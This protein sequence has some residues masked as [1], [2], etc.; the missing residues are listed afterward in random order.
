MTDPRAATL[1]DPPRRPLRVA[2]AD[3][4]LLRHLLLGLA[5][6]AALYVLSVIFGQF[7]DLRLATGAYYFCALAG[8]TFL[9][10]LNGQVSLGHGAMMGVGAYTAALLIGDE[11]WPL[12]PALAAA[13]AA[14]AVVGLIAGA[15]AARLR[16][17]YVAGATLALA[18]GLPGV[19]EKFSS[20][21]GGDN[22]LTVN[23]SIPPS[24]SIPLER[25]QA[26][27]AGLAA[28]IVLVLLANLRRSHFG[29]A[30][31]AVADDEVAAELA[32]LHLART[33]VLAFVTSSACA[34]LAGGLLVMV[35]SLV[36][37]LAFPL[38]LSFSLLTGVVLGGLGSLAGAVWGAI[39]LVMLPSWS[40]DLA[41]SFSVSAQVQANIPLVLYGV[42]L[43]VLMLVA[44]YGIQGA[45]V[46][47][48]RWVR[49]RLTPKRNTSSA[50]NRSIEIQEGP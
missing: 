39:A 47:I 1:P 17:P 11:A 10:G 14:G 37:P 28:V 19:T 26:W 25:W 29:R 7:D 2:L 22:G 46:R 4:T 18:V 15:A 30:L 31:R 33:R 32:G 41:H 23:P 27:I 16:G 40:D 42:V 12:V 20:L 48:A 45:L 21:F 9:T 13:A 8:L 5:A 35:T 34:G 49:D 38:E 6:A 50:V 43:I 36:T 24:Q 3:Q 44:P